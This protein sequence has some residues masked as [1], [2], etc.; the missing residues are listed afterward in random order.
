MLTA[1]KDGDSQA[2]GDKEQADELRQGKRAEGRFK[3][4]AEEL[5]DKAAGSVDD[6][7]SRKA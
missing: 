6:K 1:H 7:E 2:C 5:V 4:A 3:V